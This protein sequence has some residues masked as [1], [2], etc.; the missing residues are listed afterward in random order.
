MKSERRRV[1][2]RLRCCLLAIR[3]MTGQVATGA[4]CAVVRLRAGSGICALRT[5]SGTS[6]SSGARSGD[7]GVC[8]VRSA[9]VDRDPIAFGF[10]GL[11]LLWVFLLSRLVFSRWCPLTHLDKPRNRLEAVE[12]SPG[13]GRR[14][15]CWSSGTT[16]TSAA[17]HLQV[18]KLSPAAELA[19]PQGEHLF[20][21]RRASLQS[22]E[23]VPHLHARRASR[24]TPPRFRGRTQ[25]QNNQVTRQGSTLSLRGSY[26][27]KS[28]VPD[29]ILR[30]DP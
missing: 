9:S 25:T 21:T 20:T 11:G 26:T 22:M 13:T 18:S 19:S 2:G 24:N 14:L 27:P 23:A 12:C 7:F 10:W 15:T 4:F 8:E 3:S 30:L 16:S 29:P 6:P 1:K 17:V 28:D 5:S